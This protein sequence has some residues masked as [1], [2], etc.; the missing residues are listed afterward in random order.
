MEVRRASWTD[1]K[2]FGKVFRVRKRGEPSWY[3]KD[4]IVWWMMVK[5]EAGE[6]ERKTV[7]TNGIVI[8]DGNGSVIGSKKMD[9]YFNVAYGKC[10]IR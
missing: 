3:S 9:K 2:R 6:Y 1:T 8:K 10:K 7:N 5:N 4:G